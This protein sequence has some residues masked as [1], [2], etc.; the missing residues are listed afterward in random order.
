M[1]HMDKI[2]WQK[3]SAPPPP[4]SRLPSTMERLITRPTFLVSFT[5]EDP[6]EQLG[7]FLGENR[8][9]PAPSTN[10]PPAPQS[11]FTLELLDEK[12]QALLH[13]LTHT[14]FQAVGNI[15][16]ELRDEIDHL[17]ESTDTLE[18]KFDK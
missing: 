7:V 12:L 10:R 15:S 9:I 17:G 13:Q 16:Q 2:G 4:E 11:V 3:S 18:T 6:S 8:S 14:I 1:H 5:K